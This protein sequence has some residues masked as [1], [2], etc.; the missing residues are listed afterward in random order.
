MN[1]ALVVLLVC[2]GLLLLGFSPDSRADTVRCESSGS[3]RSCPVDGRSGVR[4]TRQLS[5]QG[6]W[7]GDTWGYDVGRIWVDRG[8][9]A[10]FQVGGASSSSSKDNAV[11]AAVVL[12]I[13]GAAIIASKDRDRDRRDG[14]YDDRYGYG[15]PRRTIRCESNDNRVSYCGLPYRGHV[16]VYRQH[17][18]S[19]CIYARSWG[20]ERGRLWVS[21]GCRADF[22]VY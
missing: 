7:Q 2:A 4:L 14:Y 22:A 16:E 20:V 10:E 8:C 21:N 13:V 18:S 12:G 6:C 19:P 11:A 5:S 17:S 9:R 3:Y 15:D 1:R